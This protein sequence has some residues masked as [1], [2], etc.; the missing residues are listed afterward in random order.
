MGENAAE[1]EGLSRA[2]RPVPRRYRGLELWRDFPAPLSGRYAGV[3]TGPLAQPVRTSPPERG[4]DT[5]RV[6]TR[7]KAGRLREPVDS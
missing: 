4:G 3:H 6:F 1:G 2:L 7:I 5:H